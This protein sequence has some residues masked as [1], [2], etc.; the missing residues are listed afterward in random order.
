MDK[1]VDCM[2][3]GPAHDF[4]EDVD[5]DAGATDNRTPNETSNARKVAEPPNLGG[6]GQCLGNCPAYQGIPLV[7]A[8]SHL[9]DI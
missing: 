7:S 5:A 3:R 4:A 8:F 9:K 1:L 2:I 6:L